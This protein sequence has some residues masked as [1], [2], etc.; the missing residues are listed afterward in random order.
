VETLYALGIDVS[1]ALQSAAWLEAPMRFF[2]FLGTLE[3]FV[4]VL[5][6]LYWC[7][8]AS[9]GI[10]VGFI[11]LLGNGLNE[12]AKMAL[13]GPRPYW[14]SAQVRGLSAETSFGAPSGHAQKAANMWG[15][16]AA[17]IHRPWAWA[18]AVAVI[19][20]IGFSRIYLGV[21]FPHDVLLGWALGA[22]TLWIFLA[23]WPRVSAW[24][25]GR[26]LTQ[27]LL[28][29]LVIPA[30]LLAI[31]GTLV[32]AQRGYVLPAEWMAN[33]IPAGEPFPAPYSMDGT[34]ASAGTLLGFG[35]GLALLQRAGGYRPS[36]PVWKRALCFV[37][38]LLGILA[39]YLGL[40]AVFPADESF[41]AWS[42]RLVRY[43]ML[44]LWVSAGAPRLFQR[45]RLVDS[46]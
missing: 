6:V 5:P 33:A 22:L 3:F 29:S 41:A 38:G 36:G 4:F 7:I 17:G 30:V 40:K 23:L 10:R 32:Y 16:L 28:L 44:G 46:R 31:N 2:T 15:V 45:L 13:Q 39:L 1:T 42:L 9:L 26:T 8:D 43:A 24:V 19:F 25:G 34:I 27:Q 14:I 12:F 37:L 11:L 21:H 35:V 18:A 20:L